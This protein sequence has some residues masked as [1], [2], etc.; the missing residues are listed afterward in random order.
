MINGSYVGGYNEKL[1]T[2]NNFLSIP[3]DKN[4]E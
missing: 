2:I 3:Y 4:R 1:N